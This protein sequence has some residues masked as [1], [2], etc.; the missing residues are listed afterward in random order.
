VNSDIFVSYAQNSEDVLLWRALGHVP[1]GRYVDVGAAHP[2]ELSV[3]KAFYDRGWRGVDVEPVPQLAEELRNAR[4]GDEVVQAA[5]TAQDVDR[6]ELHEIRWKSDASVTGL[7]TL[8]GDVA[9]SHSHSGF[10]VEDLDVKAT[11]L[12]A[13]CSAAILGGV[14]HFLKIDVEGAEADV[15]HSMDFTR[16]RPWIV[17]V[18]ATKP[19]STEPSHLE[20]DPIL[21]AA[22]YDFVLFDGLSRYYVAAEHAELK[23][24]LSYPVCVFDDFETTAQFQM[25]RALKESEGFWGDVVHWRAVALEAWADVKAEQARSADEREDASRRFEARLRGRR[26]KVRELRA[27]VDRMESSASWRVTRPLRGLRSRMGRARATKA[28]NQ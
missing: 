14:I 11:T 5:V 7:S 23:H 25:R 13:L 21:V 8:L 6:L 18:E 22:D 4:P 9:E 20:W 10:V 15:L 1:N 16:H 28:T 24:A 19:L 26:A 27:Q 3:T 2:E 12:S 17:L